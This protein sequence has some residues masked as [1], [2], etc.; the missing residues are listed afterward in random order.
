MPIE[1][2]FFFV[3]HFKNSREEKKEMKSIFHDGEVLKRNFEELEKRFYHYVE[4]DN[5]INN[6]DSENCLK[7]SFH[8]FLFPNKED[9]MV[10]K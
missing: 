1:S 4:H 6:T 8:S 3:N 5:K 2:T 10:Q 7:F 9:F